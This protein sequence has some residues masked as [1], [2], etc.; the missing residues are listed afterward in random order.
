VAIVPAVANLSSEAL[1]KEEAMADFV[2]HLGP[3]Q[4]KKTAHPRD[5]RVLQ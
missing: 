5:D 4:R 3:R 1:A 2:G